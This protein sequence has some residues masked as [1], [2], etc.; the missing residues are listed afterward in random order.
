MRCGRLLKTLDEMLDEALDG[1]FRA[2]SYDESLISKIESNYFFQ[3]CKVRERSSK[4]PRS[5][6]REREYSFIAFLCS[7]RIERTE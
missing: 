6:M 7:R 3:K 5:I 4:E 1:T 2:G